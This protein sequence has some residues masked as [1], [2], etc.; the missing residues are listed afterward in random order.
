[1]NVKGKGKGGIKGKEGRNETVE[2]YERKRR[3]DARKDSG[4]SML[5]SRNAEDK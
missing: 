5:D 3:S 4:D 1:M 2:T